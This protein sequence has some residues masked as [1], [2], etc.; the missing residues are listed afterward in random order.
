MYLDVEQRKAAYVSGA[1]SGK[2]IFG[3]FEGLAWRGWKWLSLWPWLWHIRQV[4]R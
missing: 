4:R 2:A 3:L 1:F